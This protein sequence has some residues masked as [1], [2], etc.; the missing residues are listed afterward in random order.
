[1]YGQIYAVNEIHESSG[2]TAR[3]WSDADRLDFS[4]DT[5]K[6]ILVISAFC[7]H[8]ISSGG[9]G[10]D[11]KAVS[12]EFRLELDKDEVEKLV[13]TAL[14]KKLLK[15]LAIDNLESID[16]IS[17]LE[18]DLNRQKEK[19]NLAE[20]EVKRL[21]RIVVRATAVLDGA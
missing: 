16:V 19:L 13:A 11:Y 4:I 7:S 8:E 10:G 14:N 18:L 21:K 3:V 2:K 17:K 6:Q 1:M 12:R 9:R 5:H 20:R 15:K